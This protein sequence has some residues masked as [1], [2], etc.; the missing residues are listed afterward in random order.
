MGGDINKSLAIPLGRAGVIV[1]GL[2]VDEWWLVRLAC[3]LGLVVVS[4]IFPFP[5]E[6]RAIHRH[7][8]V[9]A[10]SVSCGFDVAPIR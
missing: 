10:A 4:N 5:C 6:G 9:R 3:C 2:G 7:L 8:A 1:G